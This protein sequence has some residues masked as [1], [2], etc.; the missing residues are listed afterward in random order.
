MG[1]MYWG[2]GTAVGKIMSRPGQGHQRVNY[3][4]SCVIRQLL[5]LR[6]GLWPS[7]S[8]TSEKVTK[9]RRGRQIWRISQTRELNEGVISHFVYEIAVTSK[10]RDFRNGNFLPFSGSFLQGEV[11]QRVVLSE[12]HFPL[13]NINIDRINYILILSYSYFIKLWSIA[14]RGNEVVQ[15]F[16]KP[17]IVNFISNTSCIPWGLMM[18]SDSEPLLNCPFNM[19]KSS[20]DAWLPTSPPPPFQNRCDIQSIFAFI[21]LFTILI[22]LF[23]ITLIKG[24]V[25]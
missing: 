12:I 25:Q 2:S 13:E 11:T 1:K 5:L 22:Y 24:I 10:T 3:L 15:Y 4:C 21:C 8:G 6:L 17:F 16:V 9:R 7:D 18:I 14:I 23:V 20:P 19:W